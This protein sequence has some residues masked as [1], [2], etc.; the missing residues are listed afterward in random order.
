[1]SLS[2][3]KVKVC[4]PSNPNKCVETFALLDNG[5]QGTFITEKMLDKLDIVG[6]KT[7]IEIQTVTGSFQEKTSFINHLQVSPVDKS[8]GS[9]V[10]LPKCY[11]RLTLPAD[12]SEIATPENIEQW[13]YLSRIK[14]HLPEVSNQSVIGLLIGTNCPKA[15]EPV[16]VIQSEGTGPYAYKTRLGW[17]V[18]GP[19]GNSNSNSFSCNRININVRETIKD[20]SLRDMIITAQSIDFQDSNFEQSISME[21]RRFIQ[22]MEEETT[23]KN[24]HYVSPLPFRSKDKAI[25]NNR[26]HVLQRAQWLKRRLSKQ[27]RMYDD[28]VKFM[29]DIISKGYATKATEPPKDSKTWYIPHH[30]VYHPKKPDK[31]RVVFDCS[32][33]ANGY[34][35]NQELLQ[36]PDLTNQLMGVLLRFR[37]EPIAVM[38]D[39]E[40]MFC[41]VRVPDDQRDCLRFLW[42]PDGNL[43]GELEEYQMCV[44]YFGITSSPSCVNFSLRKTATDNKSKYGDQAA[45]VLHRNFYV[46]DMLKS[47]PDEHSAISTVLSTRNMCKDGGFRLTKFHS[48]S[49]P[50]EERSKSLKE[51]DMSIDSIP[52]ERALGMQWCPERDVF[53][54]K[55]HFKEKPSTRRGVLSAVSSMYD[56]LGLISPFLLEGKKLLQEICSNKHGWDEPLT[57]SQLQ[58]FERWKSQLKSLEQFEIHRCFKPKDFGVVANVSLHHFSDGAEE[59]YGQVSYVRYLNDKGEV[60]CQLVLSKSRVAP[61]KRPTIPRLELSASVVSVKVSLFLNRELDTKVDEE[62]FWT[63]AQVVLSYISNDSKRFQIFVAN[64]SQFVREKTQL[65]QWYYVPSKQNPADHASKGLSQSSSSE[66][67]QHWFRGPDFLYQSKEHWPKQPNILKLSNDDKEVKKVKVQST[68]VLPI[69]L[70]DVLE[71]QTNSWTKMVRIIYRI[72]RWSKSNQ[73]KLEVEVKQ[74]AEKAIIRVRSTNCH[75]SSMEKTSSES[76]DV[77]RMPTTSHMKR[78]IQSYCRDDQ[79]QRWRSSEKFMKRCNTEDATQRCVD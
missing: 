65:N 11:T 78:S 29:N 33:K 57:D 75:H 45:E 41:Q 37:E 79:Q 77:S 21:D 62:Y 66:K 6:T 20:L 40:A 7:T 27:Q 1:V 48:E 34:C 36:G 16:E 35:L 50:P 54:F 60:H 32:M 25:P 59:G 23:F 46:D 47:F 55:V 3:V 43:D 71:N 18:S 24:G 76:E 74:K 22:M 51:L 19:I 63:D 61:L 56:P 9:K 42:W 4:H 39:I 69:Q 67:I 2:I 30:G 14:R 8:I 44:H 28:Y 12:G 68:K 5:S 70:I 13:S 26:N 53:T 58:R 38:G 17:C 73:R 72:F 64:R 31:I 15:L 52:N 49:I 10:D